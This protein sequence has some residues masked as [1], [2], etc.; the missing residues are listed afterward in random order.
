[1]LL[2]A[3]Y[4]QLE[5]RLMAHFSGDANLLA[6]LRF[7]ESDPFVN[8][9]ANWLNLPVHE[10]CVGEF[11]DTDWL[12]HPVG[13][14]LHR[15]WRC[16]PAQH[17]GSMITALGSQDS[18][19]IDSF[20]NM[21]QLTGS[22]WQYMQCVPLHVGHRGDFCLGV[23]LVCLPLPYTSQLAHL[24]CVSWR[25]S[26]RDPNMLLLL[27]LLLMLRCA[28]GGHGST[29]PSQAACLRRLVR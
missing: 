25:S 18:W 12:E 7:Q 11:G 4:R 5:L 27:L 17:D 9:A 8:L 24:G 22:T 6:A 28:T 26:V 1:V 20:V 16:K 21:C 3:D 10:V 2:G 15:I 29:Q 23:E 19:L 13:T 14:P